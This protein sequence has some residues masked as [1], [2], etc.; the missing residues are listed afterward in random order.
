[1]TSTV[2]AQLIRQFRRLPGVG[3]KTAT[4]YAYHILQ[5]DGD[6][7]AQL[8]QSLQ[9]AKEHIILCERCRDYTEATPCQI[10]SDFVRDEALL[11]I[12]EKPQDL[13][14]IERTKEYRGRYFVLHGLISPLKGK[15]PDALRIDLLQQLLQGGGTKELILAVSSNVEGQATSHY[16]SQLASEQGIAVSR[17]ASGIPIGTDLEYADYATLGKAIA[18]RRSF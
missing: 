14:A 9:D 5:A 6:V 17:L 1:M 18:E 16:I 12:V 11:C 2:L 8:V 10:C 7:A 15:G 13:F 4:R 3:E